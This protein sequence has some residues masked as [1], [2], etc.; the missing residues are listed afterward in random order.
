MRIQSLNIDPKSVTSHHSRLANTGS[1]NFSDWITFFNLSCLKDRGPLRDSLPKQEYSYSKAGRNGNIQFTKK[2]IQR[3]P[4]GK[5]KCYRSKKVSQLAS[6]FLCPRP[7]IRDKRNAKLLT[8]LNPK[9]LGDLF[10][11][12]KSEEFY[13]R[14]QAS[15]RKEGLIF[16]TENS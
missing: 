14:N 16:N 4:K 8:R 11:A 5:G 1:G 15:S 10:G 12:R 13:N 3:L 2:K 9:P 6:G 7:K